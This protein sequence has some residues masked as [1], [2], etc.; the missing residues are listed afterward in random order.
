M[1]HDVEITTATTNAPVPGLSTGGL[2]VEALAR[3]D[4]TAMACSLS[5]TVRFR[6]LLPP[7]DVDVVGRDATM[8]EFRRWFADEAEALEILTR[9]SGRS[10]PAST[11]GG[12]SA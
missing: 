9:R 8:T 4:F 5:P 11:C 1:L 6:A 7:R 3:R 10:V 2:F 12:A